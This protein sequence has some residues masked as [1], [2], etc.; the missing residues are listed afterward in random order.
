MYVPG[1]TKSAQYIVCLGTTVDTPSQWHLSLSDPFR[2]STTTITIHST[3]PAKSGK[4]GST[5]AKKMIC[6][7]LPQLHITRSNVQDGIPLRKAGP[8]RRR[9]PA[10]VASLKKSLMQTM[11]DNASHGAA[12]GLGG[13]PTAQMP[14]NLY[15]STGNLYTS[16]LATSS[17]EMAGFRSAYA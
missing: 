3:R 16:G 1:L 5:T 7:N 6:W 14:T 15:K 13:T 4:P 9:S 8:T 12:I 10:L 17:S 2:V 11:P